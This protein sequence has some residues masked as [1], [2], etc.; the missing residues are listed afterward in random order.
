MTKKPGRLEH[1]STSAILLNMT[2]ETEDKMVEAALDEWY[3]RVKNKTETTPEEHVR[4]L[5]Q[6]ALAAV[7]LG[8]VPEESE[9]G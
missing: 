8:S 3:A 4:A 9:D 2:Q 7:V 5:I 1:D 6:A